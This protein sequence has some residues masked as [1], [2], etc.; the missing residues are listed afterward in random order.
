[1][2][3]ANFDVLGVSSKVNCNCREFSWGV[4]AAGAFDRGHCKL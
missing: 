4:R 1:M 2:S 3:L